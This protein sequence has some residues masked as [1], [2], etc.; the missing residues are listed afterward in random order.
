MA[1]TVQLLAPAKLNL[2]L[3]I[4]SRRDDG[5]HEIETLFV[6]LRLWDRLEIERTP[7]DGTGGVRLEI[8]GADL[9][10]GPA[11]LAARAAQV[12]CAGLGLAPDL[13]IRLDK[14]IP[15][16]AGLGGRSSDAAAVL[17]GLEALCGRA[18]PEPE[19]HELARGLGADVPFFLDPRPAL[20]RGVGDRLEPLSGVPEQWW[21]LAL[22]PFEIATAKAYA[23][24]ASRLRRRKQDCGNQE[25]RRRR[26]CT[27]NTPT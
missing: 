12:G 23:A 21:V 15:V 3:H 8:S 1:G 19:R 27:E 2:G 7:A 24:A 20:G 13:R 4:L 9:A 17:L 18:L 11:N 5:Y 10:A 14:R 22:L 26:W 6:P 16:A 25:P